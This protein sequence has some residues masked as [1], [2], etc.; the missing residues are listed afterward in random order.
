MLTSVYVWAYIISVHYGYTTYIHPT[1]GYALYH[2]LP[3]SKVAL[4]GTYLLAWVPIIAYGS[5]AKPAQAAAALIYALSYVPIQLSLLFQ[6]NRSYGELFWIQAMLAAS[7]VV[8]FM[9]AKGNKAPLE[10]ERPRYRQM[11]RFVLLVALVAAGLLWSVNL[12]RLQFVSFADVYDVRF[13]AAAAAGRNAVGDYLTS[14]LNYCFTSYF[15]ARGL[16][17]RKWSFVIVG[18][19]VA[20]LV[21]MAEGHK[22]AILLLPL[23]LGVSWLWGSGQNFLS[24]LL[25]ALALLIAVVCFLVPDEG[26][27]VWIKAILLVR[28]VGSGGWLASKY[29]EYFPA[30]GVTYF[31]HIRPINAL[32]G[33]YPYGDLSLGQVIGLEYGGSTLANHN[34]SFWASDGFAALGPVG[35]LAVTPLVAGLLYAMNRIM[36]KLDAKFAVLW[37]CGFF[38]ALLNVPLSTALL[39]GGG[40]IIFTQA[41]WLSRSRRKPRSIKPAS[42]DVPATQYSSSG[43]NAVTDG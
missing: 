13:A 17:H 3:F 18:L 34:A 10:L 38:I 32:T 7:M 36:A 1:F 28:V 8:L 11:D 15:F 5:S 9:V 14:W 12:G 2:Y 43:S 27:G 33:M 26:V 20:V 35:I 25:L 29:L 42:L 23:T 22:S 4:L 21:Y 19:G 24:R 40:L 37:M 39:S 31:S 30:A 6:V 16:S 41:W